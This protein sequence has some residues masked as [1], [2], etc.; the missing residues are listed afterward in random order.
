MGF[1][2]GDITMER[3]IQGALEEHRIWGTREYFYPV[4]SVLIKANWMRAYWG[5]EP[6]PTHFLP[7]LSDCTFHARVAVAQARGLSVFN[8]P[9]TG[10][11]VKRRS[12]GRNQRPWSFDPDE[13]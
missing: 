7:R 9:P 8:G 3:D 11:I 13:D 4:K 10:D 1:I 5:I 12:G 2:P 6:L